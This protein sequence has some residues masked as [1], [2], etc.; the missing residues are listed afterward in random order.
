MNFNSF[1]QW[2][3]IN[4]GV[5][6]DLYS[7]DY[8]STNDIWIGSFNQIIK[9][10]NGG[11]N[12]I[13][14]GP[15]QD[16][17]SVQILPANM[18]DLALTS[19]NNAIAGG[20]F[21]GGNTECILTTSN[22]GTNWTLASTNNSVP[23]LRYLNSVDVSG[24]RAV[25]VGNNGRIAISSNTG[26][27]WNFISAGTTKLINDVKFVSYDTVFAAGDGI[28]LK[29]INGG[30]NWSS[31]TS[32]TTSYKSI[33]CKNNVVYIGSEYNNTLLKSTNYGNSY[34][35]IPLPF[36]ST[37][38]ICAV[39]KDTILCAANDG[40]YVSK[41]GGQ[42]WE[43]YILS[44]YNPIK[45]IDYLTPN[46]LIAVGNL[47]YTIRTNNLPLAQ[48]APICSFSVQGNNTNLCLGDSII[49][50]NNTP[51]IPGYTYQWKLN[52]TTFSN[53][54]NSGYKFNAAG[55]YTIS[56]SVTNTYTTIT[57][58]INVSVTG[59]DLNPLTIINSIND[60][61]CYSNPFGFAI[62]NSQVGV[63]YIFR[64]GYTT[65]SS[66]VGT[67]G[68]LEFISGYSTT[69]PTANII[70]IRNNGCFIDSL[71]HY[72]T[73]YASL[74]NSPIGG[75]HP[76]E[77]PCFTAVRPGITNVTLNNL[78]YT[79][80]VYLSSYF[81]YS[82]CKGTSLTIGST[83]P[84]SITTNGLGG[85]YVKIWIDYNNDGTFDNVTEAAYSGFSNPTATG[86]LTVGST[87]FCYQKLRMRVV[88]GPIS[89]LD[90]AVI[91]PSSIGCSQIEDYYVT[92]APGNFSPTANF[93][94]SQYN[95]CN[96]TVSF[97]NTS[98]N[99]T[100]YTWNFGDGTS[101]STATNTTHSY[102]ITGI[103][104]A[105]LTACNPF[106]CSTTT[107]S[108]SVIIPPTPIPAV[109][110]PTV[111]GSSLQYLYSIS[112]DSISTYNSNT[113]LSFWSSNTS[114]SSICSNQ[115]TLRE[116]KWY[117]IHLTYGGFGL[118]SI[119]NAWIDFNNDGFFNQTEALGVNGTGF[120][121]SN[122]PF[123]ILIPQGAVK[124]TPLRLRFVTTQNGGT[125]DGGCEA[126]SY[127][128][129]LYEYTVFIKD[130]LPVIPDF[131][132]S[133]NTVCTNSNQIVTF[134][135][136]SQ[137]AATAAWDYGDGSTSVGYDGSHQ[138]ITAGVYNV[139]MKVTNALGSDSITKSNFITVNAGLPIPILTLTGSVLS[140]TSIATSYQWYNNFSPISGATSAS[141]TLTQSGDYQLNISNGNG[142]ASSSSTF[143][144]YPLFVDFN[145]SDDTVCVNYPVFVNNNSQN[146]TNYFIN[147]GDGT[148]NTT[149][150]FGTF[151]PTYTISG[152]YQIKVKGCNGSI[153]D[154][155]SKD[156]VIVDPPTATTIQ[157][158]GGVLTTTTVANFY[159]WYE[160]S[161]PIIGANSY[162]FVPVNPAD[163]KLIVS[164]APYCSVTSN[165]ISYL[166]ST[167]IFSADT[168]GYCGVTQADVD[169]TDATVGGISYLWDF[170]DGG[171]STQVNPNHIY[172]MP[173]NYTVKLKVCNISNCD[174]LT[175]I[176]YIQVSSNPFLT[177][178]IT[179]S[180]SLSICYSM[181]ETLMT[182]L[183]SGNYYQWQES[184][185]DITSANTSSL[186]VSNN[187]IFSVVI[188][189]TL[190]CIRTSNTVTVSIDGDCVWP[191]DANNDAMVD[192]WDILELGLHINDVGPA[193]SI[194]SNL[195]QGYGASNW[196]G[197]LMYG[198]NK[199]F[200]DCNGDGIINSMDTLAIYN[201]YNQSHAKPFETSTNEVI[202]IVPDQDSVLQ[203]T[204]GT[205]SIFLANVTT[206]I[207]NING[208]AFTINF[209]NSLIDLN[210][211]WLEYPNSFINSSNQNLH[212]RKLDFNNSVLYTATTH[213]N[214]INVSGYGKI[215]ILHYKIKPT[216]ATDSILNIGIINGAYSDIINGINYLSSGTAT[217]TALAS[218]I[219]TSL[220]Q[221]NSNFFSINPNPAASLL[222]INIENNMNKNYIIE[223]TNMLG[224]LVLRVNTVS[225]K[226]TIDI[227]D[228]SNGVYFV[229]AIGANNQ[230]GSKKIV[231]Q[232]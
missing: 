232:K 91:W 163:Y 83:Y 143:T 40:L 148:S 166:P 37:G 215:G 223:I 26:S 47:G 145:L 176:N 42:Y 43:K 101:V 100:T 52:N 185:N 90:Y 112:I 103:Y 35:S 8:Y 108:I 226:N 219:V 134:T 117:N 39:S 119:T 32:F 124:N 147:W 165:I 99:S 23:L 146:A 222:H 231:I 203:G 102:S 121:G 76:T 78:N 54:Y 123:A 74:T 230:I 142:C 135:N 173:G 85:E 178:I 16:N 113:S 11:T 67:G 86:T 151:L 196:P 172:T 169:F 152:T 155:I 207:N 28:I 138:Y 181:Q 227:S 89:N 153:C 22:S 65:I 13:P 137:N 70:A 24:N 30:S 15:I 179:P 127:Q 111:F 139:K 80:S 114:P 218:N 161:T 189:N 57:N 209:D 141:Y 81:D 7:V 110:T 17:S 46:Q 3:T 122:V 204:W 44:G 33:S 10:T 164:N 9:T 228:L 19:S 205:S 98:L 18:N 212:F 20:L 217:L 66:Q 68:L 208:I 104:N 220:S 156:V 45:M 25:I 88:S 58:S 183:I 29:S 216:L 162:S 197:I 77:Y 133:T 94:K 61:A 224:E 132:A 4:V 118:Q 107:Q 55:N 171:T 211:V 229:K 130:A 87:M 188:T 174:S 116:S 41:T 150:T 5:T 206:P 198:D 129:Y 131:T 126:F 187:G 192:N 214:N 95:S 84:V 225:Q 27:T 125:V 93:V 199:K 96:S 184:G 49:L 194:T 175:R 210:S 21:Y 69:N 106:G 128:G 64:S 63:N 154:S 50:I 62:E 193:R 2:N 75:V 97:T 177:P 12:W 36:N 191:G 59:H 72:K 221:L 200:A 1:S 38:I 53:Q 186:N 6:Q 160:Y 14:V 144:Y 195:W 202:T 109:C 92:I 182:N 120:G 115:L 159:Q 158:L 79:T 157:N 170:G 136:I 56:L 71:K 149:T 167:V 51:N 168:L 73:F 190:G 180:G 105:S 201:N 31:I 82:C 140:T 34:T 48:T 60:S 213:T